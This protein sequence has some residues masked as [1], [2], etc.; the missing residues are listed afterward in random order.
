MNELFRLSVLARRGHPDAAV[1]YLARRF[2]FRRELEIRPTAESLTNRAFLVAGFDRRLLHSAPTAPIGR[3][4]LDKSGGHMRRVSG[5]TRF[6]SAAAIV[7]ICAT[8]VASA[9]ARSHLSRGETTP[10]AR[11]L[12]TGPLQTGVMDPIVFPSAEAL[13]FRRTSAAGATT[14]RLALYW[15]SVAPQVRQPSFRPDDPADPAYRWEGIDPQVKLAVAHGLSPIISI[16]SAP[17]WA[18]GRGE[19][20]EGTVRPDPAELGRFAKAAARR[21]SGA[22]GGLPRVRHWQVWNEPNLMSY[23]SPQ[24]VAGRPFSPVWYRAM[25]NAYSDA[26]HS[27]HRDN[28]VVAGGQAPFTTFTG[29]ERGLGIGPLRFMRVMLCM[30]KNLKP[31]CKARSRFD[32][33]AHHPYT[34]GGPNHHAAFPDDVSLADLPEMRRLLDAALR[35]GKIVSRRPVRFWV[36]EFSWDTSPPDPKGVPARTHARWVSEA[37]YRMWSNGISLVTWFQLRDEPFSRSSYLQS[38]LYYR[39]SSIERDRPKPALSAFRF[40]FVALPSPGGAT[41][42]GR[43]PTSSRGRVLLQTKR[44]RRWLPVAVVSADRNGIFQRRA[45]HQAG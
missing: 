35:A 45:E 7:L 5:L 10:N 1:R 3:E 17:E 15:R 18:E 26:V 42:W 41:V 44:G 23:I 33:W 4:A 8:L 28:I 11:R 40:P 25:V 13:L 22:F 30:G 12:A 31:T 2:A 16:L 39:G 24:S 27:V 32:V 34:S 36:T 14:I 6:G 38:G 20:P 21:Y 29:H 43:T 9:S 37:L 19:G